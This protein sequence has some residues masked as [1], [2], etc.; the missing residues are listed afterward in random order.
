[1]SASTTPGLDPQS[2]TNPRTLTSTKIIVL[3][4]AALTPLSVVVG[5]LPLGLAFGGPSTALM[6]VA[7]GL[8]IGLF[9]VGYV[10]MVRRITRPGA[11]FNYIARGLGRPAGVGAAMIAVITYCIGLIAVYAVQAFVT[12]EILAGFGLAV[13]W[14]ACFLVQLLLVTVLAYRKIDLSARVTFVIVALELLV[15]LA[16]VTAIVAQK[17]P[18][19]FPLDAISPSVMGIGQWTVAFVFAILCYQG[20]EAGALYAPEAKDPER[21]VPRALYGALIVLTASF[22]IVAWVLTGVTG[23]DGLQET[24]GADPAGFIFTTMG[25]YLGDAGVWALSVLALLAQLACTLAY[26]N[27][28]SRYLNSLANEELLPAFLGRKNRHHSPGSAIVALTV[29]VIVAVL[30]LSALGVDPYTEISPVGFG[31][32]ALG[33]TTLQALAS[34]AVVGFFLR[35]PAAERHWWK[36][37]L[38]P[39]AAT[40]LLAAALYIELI[41]FSFITGKDTPEM[42]AV[43]WAIPLTAVLGIAFGFWLRKNRPRIYLSLAAGDTAEEAAEIQRQRNLLRSGSAGEEVPE[44]AGEK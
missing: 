26:T 33:A 19:A 16:L 23:V 5:T 14:Q 9:C 43:P 44:L 25:T 36:T 30:G 1:M 13:P 6:F 24:V 18:A 29:L 37:T 10:Q 41:S 22:A 3:I 31:L 4:V 42:L 21:T 35:Q 7:S 2:T 17:G 39:I 28:T 15:L 40:V 38:A 32:G 12:Q 27:F 11:F 20:F 34:A 8:I